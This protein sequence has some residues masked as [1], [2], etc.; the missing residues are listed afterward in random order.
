MR[1]ARR[2]RFVVRRDG[3]VTRWHRGR[4]HAR[5]ADGVKQVHA[6]QKDGAGQHDEHGVTRGHDFTDTTVQDAVQAGTMA[7]MPPPAPKSPEIKV[8]DV[9]LDRYRVVEQIG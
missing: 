2:R 9:V 5:L 8:G 4:D 7:T 6:G 1:C 3:L